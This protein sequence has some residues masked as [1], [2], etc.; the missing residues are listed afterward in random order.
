MPYSQLRSDGPL[1]FL[2]VMLLLHFGLIGLA[3][4][5]LWHNRRSRKQ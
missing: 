5:A 3:Y 4:W 2:V 1:W